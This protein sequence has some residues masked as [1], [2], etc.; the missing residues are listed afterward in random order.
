MVRTD[1][2]CECCAA[3]ILEDVRMRVATSATLKVVNFYDEAFPAT[4]RESGTYTDA[5]TARYVLLHDLSSDDPYQSELTDSDEE[6]DPD[7]EPDDQVD[8]PKPPPPKRLKTT[9]LPKVS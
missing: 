5:R 6:V 1:P 2:V 4:E 9:P 8:L 7:S 3:V